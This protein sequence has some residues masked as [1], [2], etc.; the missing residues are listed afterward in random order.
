MDQF[1]EHLDNVGIDKIIRIG[2]QSKSATLEGKNLRVVSKGERTTKSEGYVKAQLYKRLEETEKRFRSHLGKM[3][4][5]QKEAT[6]GNLKGY[7]MNHHRSIYGQF[8]EVDKDGFRRVGIPFD[9]WIRGVHK[10]TS[11]SSEE[12][13]TPVKSLEEIL[14]CAERDIYS[15]TNSEKR[16]LIVFWTEELRKDTT[17]QL[18][19]L[20]YAADGAQHELDGVH[21]D[22]NRR[23]LETAD[24]I[25][26]TT[27]G[28]AKNIHILRHIQ[29]KVVICEEAGEVL[30]AHMLSALLPSVEHFIQ[31]G[32]HRQLRPKVN[33]FKEL[34]LESHQGALYQLDRSQFERLST[35]EN[36][37][38]SFPVAQL[39]VQ[40]RMRPAISTLIRET[41]YPR[42]IDHQDTKDLPNVVGIRENVFFLNHK[43]AEEAAKSDAYQKSRSNN[44]EVEMTH[45]L[46][47]HVVRQGVYTS[48]DIAV[49]TPYTG[50]LQKL[51]AKMRKEFEIVLSDR[52]Q[53]ELALGGFHEVE[54]Q[55][56]NQPVISK[57]PLQKKQMSDMLRLATVDNFQGEEA[58]IIIISLVRSNSEKRV[59]F[60]RTPNRINVLL[61]RA[62]HGMYL[63]G[64]A[65][66][67]SNIPMW[68]MV[69]GM[70]QATESIGDA[71]GLCCPQHPETEIAVSE[72]EDFH[73]LSPEG[74]CQ[75]ICDKRSQCGHRCKSRCHSDI[76]H[77]TF[78]CPQPCERTHKPCN[79]SCKKA[80]CGEDCGPCLEKLDNI[81]LPCGHLKNSVP[82]YKTQ[83]LA[84]ISCDT[85]TE[86]E[87]PA[88][89]HIVTVP[90]S[91]DVSVDNFKCLTPCKT[92][93]KCGDPC[94]GTCGQCS[95]SGNLE[96]DQVKHK[97][98]A[99]TCGRRF[100]T[101]NHT[102]SKKCHVGE[103]CGLCLLPCQVRNPW[104]IILLHLR[105]IARF[106]KIPWN[107]FCSPLSTYSS[108]QISRY[109]MWLG[110][111]T[112][113]CTHIEST[114]MLLPLYED[115]LTI[116]RSV[117]PILNARSLVASPVHLVSKNVRGPVNTKAIVQ[118]HAQLP[119]HGCRVTGAVE[120]QSV[121]VINALVFAENNAPTITARSVLTKKMHESIYSKCERM[122]RST[123][124]KLRLSFSAAG[125]SS[126]RNLLTV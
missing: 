94:P 8:S 40:R 120:N 24:V 89:K 19:N 83:N 2:S 118:C 82:C 84:K 58:K 69:I 52:D 73:R 114:F 12:H 56:E 34:S 57:T 37:R 81:T 98:C 68:N 61:S 59:G 85:P 14:E 105:P 48:E 80:T 28:L 106:A 122:A 115:L 27:S 71:L 100:G 22:V 75:R 66:T 46:V 102:C 1:L 119:A 9:N 47:R 36:G 17:E 74:G 7:L 79:H 38:T 70:L 42:L 91:R 26:V 101:C 11:V 6:W 62:K 125:I 50:Q 44:W 25:G 107:T 45:A 16:Q 21:N 49:L 41:L 104:R 13:G 123:L 78:P 53:D 5:M 63:I 117:A 54:N 29:S 72:P 87:V 99:R 10:A 116:I 51:R 97:N 124:M 33:N 18:V 15:L 96:P 4:G 35:N 108:Y 76:M 111:F 95:N 112:S 93:L 77:L 88:C 126:S 23:V 30:E 39:N 60:L 55:G 92:I 64:D 67:Y 3:H 103:D 113:F 31:I 32:D 110:K 43:N 20:S 90:C 86:K 109:K 121:V 65:E